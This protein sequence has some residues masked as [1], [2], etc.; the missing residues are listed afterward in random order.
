[1]PEGVCTKCGEQQELALMCRMSA[2]G[3]LQ[4]QGDTEG[5]VCSG[6]SDALDKQWADAKDT[7]WLL[8]RIHNLNDRRP[9]VME[10]LYPDTTYAQIKGWWA[11]VEFTIPGFF[12]IR[13]PTSEEIARPKSASFGS[14]IRPA[15][16]EEVRMYQQSCRSWNI[17]GEVAQMIPRVCR[18][19]RIGEK[20]GPQ[21]DHEAAEIIAEILRQWGWFDELVK[22]KLEGNDALDTIEDARHIRVLEIALQ[23]Q[24]CGPGQRTGQN[25][26]LRRRKST[27]GA[28]CQRSPG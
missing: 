12:R 10:Y 27:P 1:M 5:C 28:G 19:L 24:G 17:A 14:T 26:E 7:E 15:T 22:M 9:S 6:C 18:E 20:D 16:P 13:P 11:S 3:Y 23:K 8:T 25:P 4:S 21:R 2:P